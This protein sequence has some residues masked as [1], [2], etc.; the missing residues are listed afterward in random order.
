[1]IPRSPYSRSP[2]R[3]V[4]RS[5]CIAFALLGGTDALAARLDVRVIDELGQPVVDAVVAVGTGAPTRA[6]PGTTATV[7]QRD[8]R[9]APGVI[10][11]Q[12]GTAVSF[13]NSDDVRHHVY[14]FSKPNDFQIKLYHGE[15][16]Q[17]VTFEHAGIVSLGCNI[18]DGMVGFIAVLDTPHFASTQASGSLS[19]D[20]LPVGRHS[21]DVWHPDAGWSNTTV[22]ID[23]ADAVVQRTLVIA[24]SMAP[25]AAANPLQSLFGD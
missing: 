20:T 10:A 12:Q 3:R 14:S 6:A 18:H 17:P 15:P 8:R 23:R 5:L 24:P 2:R 4:A 1:M 22:L 21:L 9:F 13:P 16:S 19:I 25:P 7:D 11:V